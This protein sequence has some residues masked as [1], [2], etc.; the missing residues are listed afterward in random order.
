VAGSWPQ[1]ETFAHAP[2]GREL[3]Q[4]ES[5]IYLHARNTGGLPGVALI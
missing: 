2:S 1:V 5:G 4:P 3:T